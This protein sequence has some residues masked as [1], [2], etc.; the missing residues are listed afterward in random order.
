MPEL[1]DITVY[2]EALEQRAVGRRLVALHVH[3]PFLLRT[4]D[5]PIQSV[6]GTTVRGV[7]R[8][9]KRIVLRL[10]DDLFAVLHLMIAGRLHWLEPGKRVPK[11]VTASFELENGTLTLTEAGTKKRA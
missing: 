9:G 8:M 5:P 2:V 11:N 4:F 10:D 1:P 7:R 3:T 6:G